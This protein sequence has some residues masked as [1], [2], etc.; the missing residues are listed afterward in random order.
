MHSSLNKFSDGR[1]N[2][3]SKEEDQL[4]GHVWGTDPVS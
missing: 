4:H 1:R 3:N 2:E